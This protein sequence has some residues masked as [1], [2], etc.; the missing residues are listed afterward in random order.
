[1]T[2][3]TPGPWEVVEWNVIFA[4]D[5]RIA[6]VDVNN[7]NDDTDAQ[8]IAAAPDLLAALEA[9]VENDMP[10]REWL[11]MAKA[12]IAKAKGESA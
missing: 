12:A 8:L 6:E 4:G 11:N 5:K 10:M 7:P 3:H 9:G 1:M 2:K